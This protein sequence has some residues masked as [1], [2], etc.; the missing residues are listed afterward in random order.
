[1]L[2]HNGVDHFELKVKFDITTDFFRDVFT[3]TVP[4]LSKVNISNIYTPL[5]IGYLSIHFCEEIAK[6]IMSSPSN[7][8]HTA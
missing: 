4:S 2:N 6:R 7:R 3:T 5:D 1:M 8:S